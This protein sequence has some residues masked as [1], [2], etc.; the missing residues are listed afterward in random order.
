MTA[1]PTLRTLVRLAA[2][3]SAA[4]ALVAGAWARPWAAR[5]D[6]RVVA[7]G[8]VHGSDDGFVAILRAAG[9]I[10]QD[11]HWSGGTATLVQTGDVTDRG[12]GVKRVLDLVRTLAK[13][14]PKAGG[15]VVPVLGNHEVMNLLGELRDVT[16]AICASFAAANAEATREK[17]WADYLALV[18]R[19][20]RLR[21]G[22]SPLPLTRTREG[23]LQAFQPGCIE[24]R[25]AFSPQGDYGRYLRELP[26]AAKV[27]GTVFMHAG[28]S[29]L[30]AHATLDQMNTQARDEL[31]RFDRFL[32]RLVRANLAEPWFRLEDIVAVAAAEVRWTTAR[33]ADGTARGEAPDLSDVDIPLVREAAEILGIDRWS[34]LA[35]D[36]PLWYRGYATADE[37]TLE[38]P[39]TALLKFWDAERLVVGHTPAPPFQVRARLQGRVF[40]I[41]TG[42]LVPVYKGTGSALDIDAGRITALYA[43]GTR[44]PLVPLPV[45]PPPAMP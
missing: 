10:G 16:P 40:V 33:I 29:P 20:A 5:A 3:V 6:G 26:I 36:G 19:R 21:R 23:F 4:I 24:Y 32:E 41:D 30:A 34:L 17:A 7:I 13:E 43:D 22:E 1:R 44:T 39:F 37:A 45:V 35:G 27:Q 14:A 28:A 31:K 8:D 42:M 18:A 9:L 12:A 15:R 25:L 11:G 2:G 38:A